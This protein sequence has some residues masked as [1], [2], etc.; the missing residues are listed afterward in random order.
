MFLLK[1]FLYVFFIFF[2]SLI[3]LE[4]WRCDIPCGTNLIILSPISINNHQDDIFFL[5]SGIHVMKS[6]EI[7]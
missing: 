1:T 7:P 6:I 2:Q 5:P 4:K 3:G